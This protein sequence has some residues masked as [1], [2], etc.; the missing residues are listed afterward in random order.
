M[1]RRND[2]DQTLSRWLHDEAGAGTAGYL[3]ET[4]ILLDRTPQRRWRGAVRRA[5]P[6]PAVPRMVVPRPL[7]Y[8]AVVGLLTLAL[9][10]A[11]VLIGSQR[12]L[13]PPFGPAANGII[14]YDDGKDVYLAEPDGSRARPIT[15]GLGFEFNPAFS[16]DGTLVAFWSTRNSGVPPGLFVAPADGS[17]PARRIGGRLRHVGSNHVPPAWSPD[18]RSIAVA[19]HGPGSTATIF[20]ASVDGGDARHVGGAGAGYPAWSPDGQWI[21]YRSDRDGRTRLMLIR[22][23]ATG[24]REVSRVP[25]LV[26]AFT[27]IAWSPDSTRLVYHRPEP[28]SENVIAV[29]HLATDRERIVSP[30]DVHSDAPTWSN[31]GTRIAYMTEVPDANGVHHE[32]F[33]VDA[34][35]QNRRPM[36]PVAGCSA[37][38]SPD[39]RYVISY[40]PGCFN[41]R[42]VI[43]PVDSDEPTR[44][45]ELPGSIVGAPSWQ[46]V[47]EDR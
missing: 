43:V 31:D 24:E 21:A 14:A 26:N 42:I 9:V 29:Y 17:E 19:D 10:A 15:G 3:E 41:D 38:W 46:R 18:S 36:G 44:T 37:W 30:L 32:L 13:P 12:R 11:A 39:D 25:D 1:I 45:V 4:L 22:P 5:I 2:F 20:V 34:G 33:V 27:Q 7:V 8:A 28:P 35:G 6:L 40:A 47:A 16:P 23:D